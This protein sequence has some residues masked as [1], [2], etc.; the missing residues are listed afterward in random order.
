[1]SSTCFSHESAEDK[2]TFRDEQER[3]GRIRRM[4]NRG[5]SG[6][7]ASQRISGRHSVKNGMYK[8]YSQRQSMHTMI[9]GAETGEARRGC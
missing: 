8:V 7:S 9:G 3:N 2:I 1:M 6:E 4:C 5:L